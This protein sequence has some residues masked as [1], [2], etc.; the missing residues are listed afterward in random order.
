MGLEVY[1]RVRDTVDNN[2]VEE[3]ALVHAGHERLH[4]QVQ[5]PSRLSDKKQFNPRIKSCIPM[6][7][8]A[9]AIP[10]VHKLFPLCLLKEPKHSISLVYLTIQV[11]RYNDHSVTLLFTY[12]ILFV[13]YIATRPNCVCNDQF[14]PCESV[15]SLYCIIFIIFV[16]NHQ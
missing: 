13:A 12:V 3:S 4:K 7:C 6:T 8:T 9:L 11:D 10:E 14:V 2:I 5:T 16:S 1:Q 15:C